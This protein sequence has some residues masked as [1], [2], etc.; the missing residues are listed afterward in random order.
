[1]LLLVQALLEDPVPLR[2]C[3]RLRGAGPDRDP[4]YLD[5]IVLLPGGCLFRV[6][7]SA[8]IGHIVGSHVQGCLI[9]VEGL[10]HQ[11]ERGA[12]CPH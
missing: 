10:R 2:S 8:C 12:N 5:R 4:V 1:M 3:A 6:S 7:G 9:G 11:V